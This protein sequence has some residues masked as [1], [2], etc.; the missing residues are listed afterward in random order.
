MKRGQ[1]SGFIPNLFAAIVIVSLIAVLGSTYLTE[2][3]GTYSI[4]FDNS[5]YAAFNQMDQVGNLVNETQDQLF[6]SQGNQNSFL[7]FIDVVTSSVYSTFIL[8]MNMPIL[9]FN[10]ASAGLTALGVPQANVVLSA[11]VMIVTVYIVF[12]VIEYITKVR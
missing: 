9:F 1:S 2:M 8:L 4:S 3:A 11:I 5:S 7:T 10:I 6:N 12:K